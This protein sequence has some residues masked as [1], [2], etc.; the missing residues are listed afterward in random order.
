MRRLKNSANQPGSET[1]RVIVGSARCVGAFA[2]VLLLSCGPVPRG[3][4]PAGD[5]R[6]QV[7]DT[8]R[9]ACEPFGLNDIAT[10]LLIQIVERD[11]LA[12]VSKDDNIADTVDSCRQSSDPDRAAACETCSVAIIEQVYGE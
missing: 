4:I 9:D 7:T 1:R 5:E 6:L 10:D 11:R 2:I 3:L 12:G 8:L